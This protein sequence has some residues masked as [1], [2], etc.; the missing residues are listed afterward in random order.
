V[1]C[2][3][4]RSIHS[5]DSGS[6]DVFGGRALCLDHHAALGSQSDDDRPTAAPHQ[7][8]AG[9]MRLLHVSD[10]GT[11]QQ[12]RLC[13]DVRGHTVLC[14]HIQNALW[15]SW[16]LRYNS[17]SCARK[18]KKISMISSTFSSRQVFFS[19]WKFFLLFFWSFSWSDVRSWVRDV[20]CVRAVKHSEA[21]SSYWAIQ[22]KQ[23]WIE[24]NCFCE[25]S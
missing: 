22:N 3:A 25:Q 20:V 6:L 2:H 13:G 5:C 4:H 15:F 19:M 1:S 21:H 14:E 9:V 10:G 11:S 12:L 16:L 24:L 18:K 17:W 7:L 23:N 8:P